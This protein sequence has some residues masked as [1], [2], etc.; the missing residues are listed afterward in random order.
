MQFSIISI[1]VALAATATAQYVSTNG[2]ATA[3][4]SA[5]YPVG[6]AGAA[7]GTAAS[8]GS[9]P[10]STS[11]APFTGGAS[12]NMAGSALGLIV[13]GGVAMVSFSSLEP[14]T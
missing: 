12:S 14:H 5:Y 8:T 4:T 11:T 7:S 13:A 6:T 2:T 3:A 10:T 1:V 9:K